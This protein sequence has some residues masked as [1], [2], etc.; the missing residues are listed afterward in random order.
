MS[1]YKHILLRHRDVPNIDRLDVYCEN[2]G[3]EA[4]KK[5]VT[6]MTAADVNTEVKNSGLRGRGGAGFP[7]GM[8]WSFLPNNIWPHYVVCNADESEPGTFKDREIMESNPFQL[9]EG[10]MIAAYGVQANVAYIYLRG[11]FWQVAKELDRRIRELE[12]QGYLGD[13]ILGTKTSLRLYTHLGAGAYICGEETALLESIEG[14]LGQPRLRP[15]FPAVYGLYGKPTVINNVETLTNI[16]PIIQNGAAW[17]K[18]FGTEKSPGVKIFS[19]SGRVNRPGNY[20]LPLGTTFRDL[21]YKYGGGVPNESPVKAILPAGASSA[22][23]KSDDRVL[24]TPMDYEAVAQLGSALGSASVIVVDDT[25]N[26]A[27]LVE[28]T[29]NFFKHESCGK[30]TPCRE[31]TYWMNHL[32]RQIASGEAVNEEIDLLNNVANQIAGKC[33]C[34]LG[35]FSIMTVMTGI[36]QFRSDFEGSINGS[37]SEPVPTA[38]SGFFPVS[39]ASRSEVGR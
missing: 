3:F 13:N 39:A 1:E 14:K 23:I 8:K 5:V 10:V 15:P 2:G 30:C 29:V 28:K 38:E 25:V 17:F 24:D 16:P 6:C 35:E 21:I 33:L 37:G 27:W 34:A 11:E 26:M 12:A 9:L 31:G 32:A 4:Y 7:T 22:I 18:T 19:L 20:E 36:K